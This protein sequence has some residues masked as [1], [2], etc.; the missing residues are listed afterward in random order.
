MTS[1]TPSHFPIVA[2]AVPVSRRLTIP[3][4][5]ETPEIA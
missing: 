4:A 3:D 2:T 5:T 1:Y